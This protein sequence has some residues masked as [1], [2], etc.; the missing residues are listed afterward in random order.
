MK[1]AFVKWKMRKKSFFLFS[2]FVKQIET[3]RHTHTSSLVV[4][5]VNNNVNNINEI[6]CLC[7][8]DIIEIYWMQIEC[9]INWKLYLQIKNI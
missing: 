1:S 8:L 2:S 7:L 9:L 3:D 4:D 5:K 6:G